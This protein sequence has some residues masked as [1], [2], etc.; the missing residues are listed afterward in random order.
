MEIPGRG[1]A[2]LDVL[3]SRGLS[4]P[5]HRQ[6]ALQICQHI[7][8]QELPAHSKIAS[9]VVLAKH[10]GVS[11]GT[12]TKAL[13]TLVQQQ[14]LYRRRPR[15]TF[16]AGPPLIAPVGAASSDLLAS[17]GPPP[18]VGMIVPFLADSFDGSIILGVE[19]VARAA[20]YGLFSPISENNWTLER[21]HIDQLL[22]RAVAWHPHFP[23][24][25]PGR[26]S[27]WPSCL[28]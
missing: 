4:L 9:E 3:D 16:V 24:R 1:R 10:Y 17:S 19:T 22:R 14:V 25:F 11:R 20:G 27:G 26:A 8:Y 2:S 23:S 6:I 15:G 5:L 21:Y 13:D 28:S 18:S 12:V 7:N